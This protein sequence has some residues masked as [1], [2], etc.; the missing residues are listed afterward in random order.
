[1]LSTLHSNSAAESIVRLLDLGMDP[2]NCA[3]ALI[4]ILSQRLAR[5][6]CLNC[7]EAYVA[8]E[9]EISDL[10][11]EYCNETPL[12]RATVLKQWRA[13]YGKD[14]HLVLRK[15]IG[16]DACRDGYKGLLQYMSCSRARRRSNTWCA[17][18]RPS[19]NC[20]PARRKA[21]CCR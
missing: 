11:G 17:R 14:G 7:A 1:V 16:C 2:F 4:G 20:C 6:L 18:T 9:L 21:A 15:A 3:D 10:L 8:S 13:D 5:R 12:D 19:R